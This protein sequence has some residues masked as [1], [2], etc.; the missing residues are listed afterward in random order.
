M[1]EFEVVA[2][3]E[4]E[5][6]RKKKVKMMP[7]SEERARIKGRWLFLPPVSWAAS[8]FS[9]AGAVVSFAREALAVGLAVGFATGVATGAWPASVFSAMRL[10]TSK[11]AKG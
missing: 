1:G 7:P 5:T 2:K 11:E 9:G 8:A 3:K 4:K 6:R 10:I